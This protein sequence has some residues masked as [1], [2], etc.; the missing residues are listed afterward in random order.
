MNLR[1]TCFRTVSAAVLAAGL[2]TSAASPASASAH[3][4]SGNSCLTVRGSK[5]FVEWVQP[6]VIVPGRV[7]FYGHVEVW[8]P[9][10]HVNSSDQ[11][12]NNIRRNSHGTWTFRATN[13]NRSFADGSR[14][15]ARFWR[16]NVPGDGSYTGSKPSCVKIHD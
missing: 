10:L 5:L 15:C 2:V 3:E 4:C 13:L 1:R 12:F 6:H 8:G 7:V 14:I 11:L 16:K 9:D